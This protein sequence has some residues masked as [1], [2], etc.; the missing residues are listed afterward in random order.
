MISYAQCF[1]FHD[2]NFRGHMMMNHGPVYSANI[3][4]SLVA[5]TGVWRDFQLI[6]I[7]ICEA[8]TYCPRLMLFAESILGSSGFQD[9]KSVS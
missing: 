2:R 4:F 5:M 6:L 8:A 9:L 7:F 1:G 3:L